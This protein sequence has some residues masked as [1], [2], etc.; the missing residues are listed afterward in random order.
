MVLGIGEAYHYGNYIL[1]SLVA[2]VLYASLTL[3]TYGNGIGFG[4]TYIQA[5]GANI[6]SPVSMWNCACGGTFGKKLIP[7]LE[8]AFCTR[9]DTS[10]ISSGRFGSSGIQMPNV[11]PAYRPAWWLTLHPANS[12]TIVK[13]DTKLWDSGSFPK[14]A[15][16]TEAAP[17]SR[18]DAMSV[19][20]VKASKVRHAMS[21]FNFCV[22]NSAF[23]ARSCASPAALMADS[24]LSFD[25]FRNSVWM[26]ASFLLNMTS[27]T[28]PA[29]I[30]RSASTDP[31][32]SRIESY[33]GCTH[34]ITNSAAMA[35]ATRPAHPHSQRSH[36]DDALSN[37]ASVAFIVPFGKRHA[38]KEFRG[39]WVGAAVGA[40]MFFVL[41]A[42]SFL[43]K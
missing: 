40:L 33:E 37:W 25:R 31:H 17:A 42:V 12:K 32:R 20:D 14:N 26:R 11:M 21:L 30:R 16:I 10:R 4:P 22:S 1:G 2:V 9:C 8:K 7:A 13:Y 6:G 23:A 19:A 36:D 24:S 41:F 35:T 18:S 5:I 29:K 27:P 39:F 3:T 43:C 28:T 34:A 15:M 38:G